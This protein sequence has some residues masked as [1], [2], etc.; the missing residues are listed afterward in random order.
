MFELDD[1]VDR[2]NIKDW[3]AVPPSTLPN[4]S[5]HKTKVRHTVHRSVSVNYGNTTIHF[6]FRKLN[7]IWHFFAIANIE[8]YNFHRNKLSKCGL[9]NRQRVCI[10][11]NA[12]MQLISYICLYLKNALYWAKG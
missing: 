8:F 3:V 10:K 1:E 6:F 5:Y 11:E 12:N 2:I 7:V 4:Q 9:Y